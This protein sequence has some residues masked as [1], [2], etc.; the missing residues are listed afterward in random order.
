MG[1][2]PASVTWTSALSWRMRQHLLEPR[3]DISATDVVRRLGAVLAM[4]ES[5][6]DSAITARQAHGQAGDLA[7]AHASGEVVVAFAYR[8]SLHYLTPEDAGLYLSVRCAGRQWEL[9]SWVEH[10]RLEAQ[11]WPDFR[12]AVREALRGGPLTVPE[13][14]E[15]L[16]R[17]RA[18]RHLRAVFDDGAGT[19]IKPLSWQGDLSLGPGKDGRRTVQSLESNPRWAGVPDLED[20]GPRAVLAYVR[21]YGPVTRAHVD[22]WFGEGLSAG[23]RRLDRWL[24]G[25]AD[26]LATV[27]IEGVEAYVA[28]DDLE[29]FRAARPTGSVRL[30]PGHD[31]WVMG[32]STKDVRVTPPQLREWM[33]RKAHPVVA[34]GVVSGTWARTGDDVTVTWLAE[35]RAPVT[36][37]RDEVQRMGAALGRELRV[38][39][40]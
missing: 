3:G 1:G 15:E 35:G 25:L 26:E 18:Y 7:R 4:D 12:A 20:A 24:A 10:Y 33:T 9:R 29:A 5:L 21:T 16:A 17:H 39:L 36:A 37:I 13:L 23:R 19:L 11:E 6:A 22:Y 31:Q 28:A 40:E 32:V 8:G 27:E 30:L 34:G 2:R 38:D 14:G